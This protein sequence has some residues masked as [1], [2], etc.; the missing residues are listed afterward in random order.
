MQA[1]S[2]RMGLGDPAPSFKDLPGVDGKRYSLESFKT[3]AALVVFWHCNHCPYSQAFE[4]R[5]NQAAQDYAPRGFGFV[6]INSN[7]AA[8]YPEDSFENMVA[9]AKAKGLVF[10]Y[11]FDESQRV[12]E[13]YGAVCTPHVFVFDA[14]RRLVYQGRVDGFKDDAAKGQAMDLRNALD[15]LL[16]GRTVRTP[17]TL[18]FGCSIK[19][20]RDHF[21][22]IKV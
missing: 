19:W 11:L 5:L 22:R 6:A 13:A 17:V 14:S 4:D 21:A 10:P 16:R 15:D 12:A 9:R 2:Y 1:T 8:E 7:D 20:G 18:A 3:K